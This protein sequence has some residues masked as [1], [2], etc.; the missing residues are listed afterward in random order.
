M[1]I[2]KG[3]MWIG[4]A[5]AGVVNGLLGS[6]GG[7]IAVP[8]LRWAGAAPTQAH[9][10]SVAIILPICVIS[11]WA[12]SGG[13]MLDW[14]QAW[15]YLIGGVPGALVGAWLLPKVPSDLLRRLFG[16]FML[17]AAVRMVMQ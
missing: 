12:Y 4:G 1:K 8:A 6:A 17:W 13:G 2:K 16:A 10:T 9:A 15:P 11:A 3:R 7:L 14:A 5:L